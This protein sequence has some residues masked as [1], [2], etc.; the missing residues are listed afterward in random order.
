[1]NREEADRLAGLAVEEA[2]ATFRR[3]VEEAR[4]RMAED[5]VGFLFDCLVDVLDDEQFTDEQREQALGR[6]VARYAKDRAV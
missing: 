3:A 4:R 6:L 2:A 5:P 1:M